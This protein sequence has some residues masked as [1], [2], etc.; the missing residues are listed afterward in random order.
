MDLIKVKGKIEVFKRRKGEKKWNKVLEKSNL[1]P[2][3]NKTAMLH[4]LQGLSGYGTYLSNGAYFMWSNGT[5]TPV[6]TDTVSTFLADGTGGYKQIVKTT[7][8]ESARQIVT[9]MYLNSLEGNSAGTITKLALTDKIPT[10][11]YGWLYMEVE[12]S[13]ITKDTET[14]LY[15]THTFTIE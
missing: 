13:A 1:I 11:P 14:E 2:S 12:F 6:S 10:S 7:Y 5:N 9:E 8:N 15:F 4:L 3:E